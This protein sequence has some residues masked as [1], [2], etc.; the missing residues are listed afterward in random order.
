MVLFKG[1]DKGSP[2]ELF[3]N[4]FAIYGNVNYNYVTTILTFLL[5][6][7]SILLRFNVKSLLKQTYIKH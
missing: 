2:I 4:V 5:C 6:L 3:L 7:I 1:N